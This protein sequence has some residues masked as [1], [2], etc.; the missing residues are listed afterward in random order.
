MCAAVELIADTIY[1]STFA[2]SDIA[3][4]KANLLKE[5]DVSLQCLFTSRC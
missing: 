2:E 5:L 3:V 1:N 4:E